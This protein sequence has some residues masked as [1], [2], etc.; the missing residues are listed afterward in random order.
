MPWI[1][2]FFLGG[3]AVLASGSKAQGTSASFPVPRK[4]IAPYRLE[5]VRKIGLWIAGWSRTSSKDSSAWKDAGFPQAAT[6]LNRIAKASEWLRDAIWQNEAD[7]ISAWFWCVIIPGFV[8]LFGVRLIRASEDRP[9]RYFESQVGACPSPVIPPGMQAMGKIGENYLVV[10]QNRT[11]AKQIPGCLAF[12]SLET[13]SALSFWVVGY[14]LSPETAYSTGGNPPRYLVPS[15]ANFKLE[16]AK[17]ASSSVIVARSGS[18]TISRVGSLQ[19]AS[20]E[21]SFDLL[22]SIVQIAQMTV[23]FWGSKDTSEPPGSPDAYQAREI[24]DRLYFLSSDKRKNLPQAAELVAQY[25]TRSQFYAENVFT[26]KYLDSDPGQYYFK[27][28][29]AFV[30]TWAQF[31]APVF[32]KALGE[33]LNFSQ[34]LIKT[35]LSSANLGANMTSALNVVARA[36]IATGVQKVVNLTPLG[37]VLSVP[38]SLP[39]DEAA[40]QLEEAAKKE[41]NDA[42]SGLQ[43]EAKALLEGLERQA[44][45]LRGKASG[46]VSEASGAIG[47]S[48]IAGQAAANLG[49]F[50]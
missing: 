24:L 45:E 20:L 5:D 36:A 17:A 43:K 16:Q 4:S 23:P 44:K 25:L 11:Q 35:A 8:W 3:A 18:E 32:G 10:P 1:L 39:L 9:S 37:N 49:K 14:F 26:E 29:N 31:A 48:G 38:S 7:A 28:F 19:V 40:K 34:G 50:F 22:V 30:S 41:A 6:E 46:A 27:A 21:T 13:L 47:G 2:Y 42:T 33:I 12:R 15:M